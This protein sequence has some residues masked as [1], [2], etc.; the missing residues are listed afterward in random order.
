[1]ADT[2]CP[3]I[4][5]ADPD[6]VRGCGPWCE[7]LH[8]V[9]RAIAGLPE[10]RYFD[11]D[12]FG[13]GVKLL[14]RGRPDIFLFKHYFTRRFL[15]LDAAGHSYRYFPPRTDAGSGQYRRDGDLL[16]AIRRLGLWEMPHLAGS[17]F[18]EE[19]ARQGSER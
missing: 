15:N 7:A 14:R 13:V 3:P 8:M 6:E 17:P 16:G 1:M 10:A 11:V 19:P 12:H 5:F 9:E 4:V 18:A 2:S